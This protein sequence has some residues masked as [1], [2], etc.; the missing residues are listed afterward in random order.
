MHNINPSGKECGKRRC[1]HVIFIL[2]DSAPESDHSFNFGLCQNTK[3]K[4]L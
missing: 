1:P 2:V 4:I 3:M